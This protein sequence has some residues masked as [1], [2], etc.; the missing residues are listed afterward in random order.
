MGEP[1]YEEVTGRDK[2]NR[3][4]R[5]YAPVG[6]HETLLAYLVCRLL[7]EKKNTS[8]VNRIADKSIPVSELVQDP[9]DEASKLTPLGLPHAKI[10]LPRQLYGSERPNSMGL[11]LSNEHRL[12]ALSPALLA[13]RNPPCR[14]G[15]S[16]ETREVVEAAA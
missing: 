4:C 7:L 15:P 10:A 3:P 2:L 16:L 12:A 6:T 14:P 5:V 8:F 9:I 11:Y 13:S 1:L